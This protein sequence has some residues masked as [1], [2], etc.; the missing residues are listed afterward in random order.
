MTF[1]WCVSP[2]L[3]IRY[4]DP[5]D[6]DALLAKLQ[7]VIDLGV[8]RVGLFVDDIPTELQHPEDQVAY[9]AL[10]DAHIDLVNA[11]FAALPRRS[12]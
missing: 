7:S 3:S 10:V 11:V 5:A 2:G 4:S 12:A 1:T 8:E 6:R 9:P